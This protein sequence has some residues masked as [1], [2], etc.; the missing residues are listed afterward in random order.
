MNS[1][2]FKI[3]SKISKRISGFE[4]RH[5]KIYHTMPTYIGCKKCNIERYNNQTNDMN[6]TDEIAFNGIVD[7]DQIIFNSL[8]IDNI[9]YI[10]I[11]HINELNIIS[12]IRTCIKFIDNIGMYNRNEILIER[13]KN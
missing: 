1:K 2:Q 10:Y 8:I 4:Y 13:I 5:D 12:T 11:T 7:D 9:I 6:N 3:L